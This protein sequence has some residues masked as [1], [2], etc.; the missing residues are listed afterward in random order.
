MSFVLLWMLFISLIPIGSPSPLRRGRA[1]YIYHMHDVKGR[2][3]LIMW[4]WTKLLIHACSCTSAFMTAT[5]FFLGEYGFSVLRSSLQSAIYSCPRR[6]SPFLESVA[7]TQTTT[8]LAYNTQQ[9][10]KFLAIQPVRC[11]VWHLEN[12]LHHSTLRFMPAVASSF[13]AIVATHVLA[14][15]M[16]FNRCRRDFMYAHMQLSCVYLTSTLDITHVI[17]CTRLPPH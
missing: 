2:H 9:I 10:T 17:K 7:T 6:T 13:H 4:G 16:S 12:L 3:D 14:S 8:T 5:V 1:W 11:H 15:I